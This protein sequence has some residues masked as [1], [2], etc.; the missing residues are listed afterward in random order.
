MGSVLA[1]VGIVSVDWSPEHERGWREAIA[2]GIRLA[3]GG[4][5]TN[6]FPHRRGGPAAR[7]T[8]VRRGAAGEGF[9]PSGNDFPGETGLVVE[10]TPLRAGQWRV[11]RR[12]ASHIESKFVKVYN[13][14]LLDGKATVK[15]IMDDHAVIFFQ[16]T[17]QHRYIK[18]HGLSYED[19]Y[20]GNA[21]AGLFMSDHAEIRFHRDYTDERIRNIWK[22][23]LAAPEMSGKSPGKLTYQ[24]REIC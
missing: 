2:N 19:D 12:G 5:R 11:Y 4:H 14:E 20:Q 7:R 8:P 21:V 13:A 18:A 1:G 23:V 15:F 22:R 6:P 9:F 3:T 10:R 24:G 16:G 17:Q